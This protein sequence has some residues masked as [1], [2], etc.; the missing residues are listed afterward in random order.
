MD[1]LEVV[2]SIALVQYTDEEDR[3]RSKLSVLNFLHCSAYLP[4]K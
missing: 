4:G 2:A 3:E 1:E